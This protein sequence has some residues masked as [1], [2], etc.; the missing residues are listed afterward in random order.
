MAFAGVAAPPLLLLSGASLLAAPRPIAD[1]A[2]RCLEA[3]TDTSTAAARACGA[4]LV[5]LA[6][7]AHAIQGDEV[8]PPE[9]R[10]L[11]L[12]VMAAVGLQLRALQ[13]DGYV[14]KGHMRSL[15]QVPLAIAAVGAA[16]R[17]S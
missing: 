14:L 13:L 10:A 3:E 9:R 12:S 7:V 8:A 16:R 11:A 2:L 5:A 1:R 4:S 15:T 17:V 6:S